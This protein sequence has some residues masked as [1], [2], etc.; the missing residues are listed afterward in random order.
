MILRRLVVEA[1]GAVR[2]LDLD[3]L[4]GG[5][6]LLYGPNEA[7]KSTLMRAV[8]W[9]LFGEDLAEPERGAASV[10]AEVEGPGGVWRLARRTTARARR[11][12]AYLTSPDLA[13][14][15]GDEAVRG[16]LLAG[17]T[18]SVFRQVFAVGARELE[19]AAG[20]EASEVAGALYSAGAVGAADLRR[21]E[22]ELE[23]EAATLWRPRAARTRV[24]AALRRLEEERALLAA[25]R[26]REGELTA[27]LRERPH[28][29]EQWTQ[30]RARAERLAAEAARWRRALAALPYREAVRAA[31]AEL[32]ALPVG[33]P[34]PEDALDRLAHLEAQAAGARQRLGRL[35]PPPP[36]APPPD[37]LR[38][39]A[40]EVRALAEEAP[41]REAEASALAGRRQ[42]WQ[43]AREEVLAAARLA[44][45]ALGEE[46]GAETAPP[47]L[48]TPEEWARLASAAEMALTAEREAQAAEAAAR[49]RAPAPPAAGADG[50][51][52]EADLAEREAVLAGLRQDV[53]R[54]AALEGAASTAG[55]GAPAFVA[56]AGAALAA[57]GA[58]TLAR[59]A[60]AL[61]AALALLAL[62]LAWV[63]GRGAAGRGRAAGREGEALARAVARAS[64][65]LGGPER[66]GA[67]D[68][69]AMAAALAR[70]REALAAKRAWER[71]RARRR[72]AETALDAWREAARTAGLP[73][74][75]APASLE[76]ARARGEAWRA[77]WAAAERERAEV[78]SL[79]GR[80]RAYAERVARLWAEA[81][82][83][84]ADGGTE[85]APARARLA[86]AVL[87]RAE[88]VAEAQSE[89]AEAE[90]AIAALCAAAA[91]EDAEDLRRRA[92]AFERRRLAQERRDAAAHAL[93]TLEAG[94]GFEEEARALAALPEGERE[95]EVAR[96]EAEA[97][98]ARNE[99]D[100]LADRLRRL[101][102]DVE[103]LGRDSDV[104]VGLDRVARAEAEV[105]EGAAAWAQAALARWLWERAKARYEEE[106]QP[107]TLA[108]ASDLF[109]HLTAGR[110]ERVVRSLGS[111]ALAAVDRCGVRREVGILSQGTRSQLYLALRLALAADYGERVTPLPVLLDDV[112]MAFDDRRRAA[113]MR[114]L[115][116]F[117]REG[118]RQVLLFTCHL[119]AVQ[120]A[121]AAGAQV[122]TLAAGEEG[123]G[124][125]LAASA[126]GGGPEPA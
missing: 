59:T 121:A 13:A 126:P 78:E 40:A 105:A 89:A 75:L 56:L 35:P 99:A 124:P 7:G 57:A 93:A 66:P 48:P 79:E 44:R 55:V 117:G 31:E 112:L 76:A 51:G 64:T 110:H 2:D 45:A 15:E 77:A 38:A 30:A 16:R 114:A 119:A 73:P 113:A 61:A 83:E 100:A 58:W 67:A 42:A 68:L 10:S 27:A 63:G 52:D 106:R 47:P 37:G 53:A 74:S 12:R 84:A 24:N 88:A 28:L 20:L 34:P 50:D 1:F 60:P 39:R 36:D 32:A 8:R 18:W 4:G 95:G 54:L 23:E 72:E 87:E 33:P 19:D 21:V 80:L 82:G 69:E 107:R 41:T 98:A 101:D 3:G 102:A 96:R 109:R 11:G 104:S 120:E 90:R 65:R 29:E 81:G 14:Y 111:G 22:R 97:Q 43:R 116:A 91:A 122:R 25:A 103:R 118:G 108:L 17:T 5:L 6:T 71:A 85:D 62:V 70:R 94:E 86:L 92:A 125:H 123:E 26:R 115:A 9:L 49:E 46:E